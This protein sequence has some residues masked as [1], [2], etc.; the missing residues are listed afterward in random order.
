V[1]DLSS[2]HGCHYRDAR[3]V[4]EKAREFCR[5]HTATANKKNSA[6]AKLQENWIH[7]VSLYSNF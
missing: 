1:L 6:I 2:N 3:S 5:G 4:G 7:T